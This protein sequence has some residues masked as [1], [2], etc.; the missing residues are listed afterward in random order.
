[1]I[2][3][4]YTFPL[5]YQRIFEQYIKISSLIVFMQIIMQAGRKKILKSNVFLNNAKGV[6]KHFLNF[7]NYY[8]VC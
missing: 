1:M 6:K 8:C 4:S 3:Y 2:V 5:K 7:E